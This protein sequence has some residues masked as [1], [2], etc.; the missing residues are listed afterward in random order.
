M[1]KIVNCLW[2]DTQAE[3]AANLYVS[4]FP[5][6][7][8]GGVSRYPEG[9][10]GDRAG[11]VMTVDF[12]LDGV[13]FLGLNGGPQFKFDEAISFQILVEDQKE[14]DHYWDG[15]IAGGGEESQCGWL[16]D[17]FGVSW[18]VVPK[19]MPEWMTNPE[20]GGKVAAAFMQMKRLDIP[21]LER[22]AAG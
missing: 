13:S 21:T 3:E 9:L 22:A 17:R 10:P 16:K 19:R 4:L 1:P 11:Q 15:L 18:Q 14:L 2:F 7:K 6:S 5:N 12:E 8:I 20:T